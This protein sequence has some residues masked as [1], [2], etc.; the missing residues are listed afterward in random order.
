MMPARAD[1]HADPHLDPLVT[2]LVPARNEARSIA[3]CLRRIAAQ[4]YDP[5]RMEVLVVV[6]TSDD[7]TEQIARDAIEALGLLNANVIENPVATT[8]NNLNV[9]LA[10]ATG[11]ILCRVDARSL[12]PTDYVSRCVSVLQSLPDVAVTGGAQVTVPPL[13]SA[14]G[15]G[16]ARA[17][18]NKWGM[19]LSRY[20]RGAPSGPADTVY[21]GAFRTG[22]LRTAGG[23]NEKFPTNQD[24]E[25]NRRMGRTG[26]VWFDAELE[27]GY[28]P[29][30]S[31]QDVFKQYRRFGNWKVRYWRTTGDRPQARQLA[32]LTVPLLAGAGFVVAVVRR[33]RS[34]RALAVGA[35]VAAAAIEAKGAE[36]PHAGS[37]ADHLYGVAAMG[38]VA[39]GWLLGVWEE[40]LRRRKA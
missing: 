30:S 34:A 26:T 18:N 8:P 27:V 25:L 15:R 1:A 32:I 22:A 5:T 33:P 35:V 14:K 6:G 31:I 3:R 4:D 13:D 12:V 20:R 2:V 38:A 40:L 24:F 7:G 19:G 21:L 36:E 37:P 29:R 39:S 28:I 23:W 11:E 16:I 9:G 10:A 17:L